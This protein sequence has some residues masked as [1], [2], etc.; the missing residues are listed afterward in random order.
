VPLCLLCPKFDRG[1]VK[2]KW[3]GRQT[4][5]GI[6]EESKVEDKAKDKVKRS[7]K[8]RDRTS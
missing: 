7:Q 4:R 3:Y 1:E 8:G 2:G 5:G 6:D